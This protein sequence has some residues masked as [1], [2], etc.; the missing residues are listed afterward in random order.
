MIPQ[1]FEREEE[2][3]RRRRGVEMVMDRSGEVIFRFGCW[4]GVVLY[5]AVL[6]GGPMSGNLSPSPPLFH[7]RIKVGHES[8]RPI[9]SH[10][11]VSHVGSTNT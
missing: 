10:F 4:C 9:S 6:V 8:G 11:L 5:P 2:V 7:N 3:E 1:W